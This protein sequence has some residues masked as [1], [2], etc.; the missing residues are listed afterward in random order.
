M[1]L[2]LRFQ[3]CNVSTALTSQ[4]HNRILNLRGIPQIHTLDWGQNSQFEGHSLER[5]I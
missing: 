2:Q 5:D 3:H 1:S 4:E